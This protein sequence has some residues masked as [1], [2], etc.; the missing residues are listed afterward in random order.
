MMGRNLEQRLKRMQRVP[1]PDRLDQRM[2]TLFDEAARDGVG[3]DLEYRLKQIRR[4]PVPENLDDHLVTLFDNAD[5]EVVTR[6]SWQLPVWSAAAIGLIL[7]VSFLFRGG[8]GPEPLVVEI[9]P[10]N[11]L[12]QF[13]LGGT[14]AVTTGGLEIFTR[15]DC[16]VETVWPT[17]APGLDRQPTNGGSTEGGR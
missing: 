15:G 16:S 2:D 5:S 11:R 13:L 12:E 4:V 3:H 8:F 6:G 17:D 9:T 1:A 14:P 7:M 10:D